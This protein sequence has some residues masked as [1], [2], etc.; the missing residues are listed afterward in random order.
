MGGNSTERTRRRASLLSAAAAC[1]LVLTLGAGR[2]LAQNDPYRTRV[3][4]LTEVPYPSFQGAVCTT[5]EAPR[6]LVWEVL[7][8]SDRAAQW[9]LTDLDGVTPVSGSY[10]K[11]GDTVGK[12][13]VVLMTVETAEG[14]RNVEL[15]VIA[16][17]EGQLLAFAVTKDDGIIAPGAANLIYTFVLED[18][19]PGKTDVYWATHYDSNSPLAAISSPLGGKRRFATRVER[20]LL[21]LKALTEARASLPPP[22]PLPE[23]RPNDRRTPVPKRNTKRR[24]GEG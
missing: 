22:P 14:V 20:G 1:S 21:V 10:K 4:G 15:K 5:V 24:G 16:A 13:D 7:T 17:A 8:S 19:G 9:L 12:D 18:A 6:A 11:K 23:I 2:A 3:R